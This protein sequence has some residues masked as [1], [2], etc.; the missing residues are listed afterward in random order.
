MGGVRECGRGCEADD[1][2]VVGLQGHGGQRGGWGDED[3]VERFS[4]GSPERRDGELEVLLSV[5]ICAE[6]FLWGKKL[7][8][9]PRFLDKS[10]ESC[11]NLRVL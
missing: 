7:K 11:F 10:I 5:S 9:H 3:R 4:D 6:R 8:T 2:A 1:G